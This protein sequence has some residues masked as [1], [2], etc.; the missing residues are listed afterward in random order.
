MNASWRFAA[1]PGFPAR[2]AADLARALGDKGCVHGSVPTGTDARNQGLT[3]LPVQ[4]L[5]EVVQG[6]DGG[7]FEVAGWPAQDLGRRP[8]R[9]AVAALTATDIGTWT[10]E[11][12]APGTGR[13]ALLTRADAAERRAALRALDIRERCGLVA[14]IGCP[15]DPGLISVRARRYLELADVV[16]HDRNLPPSVVHEL[17]DR[18]TDV[19]K[20][21]WGEQT[22]TAEIHRR[23]LEASEAGKL[24]VRLHGGDPLIFGHLEEHL[25]FLRAWQIPC[26][27]VPALT[28]AQIAAAHG[29][30]ALTRRDAVRRLVVM[31]GHDADRADALPPPPPE[32]HGLAVYMPTRGAP[33]LARRLAEAGWPPTTPVLAAQR[34]GEDEEHLD[35]L[36]LADLETAELERPAVLLVGHRPL[37][38]PPYTLFVG[39]GAERFL[40]WG[41]LIEFPVVDLMDEPADGRRKAVGEAWAD[42]VGVIFTSQRSVAAFLSSLPSERDLRDL[43]GK[44]LLTVGLSAERALAQ[45][46]LRADGQARSDGS[47]GWAGRPRPGVYLYA[48][49]DQPPEARRERGWAGEGVRIRP[50]VLYRNQPTPERALPRRP[51][52]RVLFTSSRQVEVYFD[53]YPEEAGAEREWLCVGPSTR[54]ALEVRGLHG[55]E[56]G[57]GVVRDLP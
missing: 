23:L 11:A 36:T 37:A 15:A 3:P 17:G 14:L 25:Q 35:P 7:A 30:T 48:G 54:R 6:L 49:S 21:G 55:R 38:E 46:G 39:T 8:G 2:L 1:P 44:A 5:D 47:V 33:A 40:R 53:R 13:W 57:V 52:R 4:S 18:A 51:F 22:S 42:A 56:V 10:D 12:P 41:P 34:L 27:L 20:E 31:S 24:V 32:G 28:A 45:A 50:L 43:H 9:V 19:G 26:D 29:F 16:F